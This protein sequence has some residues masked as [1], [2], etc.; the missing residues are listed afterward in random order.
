MTQE[1][2]IPEARNLEAVYKDWIQQLAKL[3]FVLGN[4]EKQ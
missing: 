4:L 1:N 2:T 3:I